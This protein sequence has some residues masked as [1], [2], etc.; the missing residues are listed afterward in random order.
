M[1]S[2]RYIQKVIA[3]KSHLCVGLDPMLEKFPAY[4]LQEAERKYGKT[5]KG[6]GAAI[7][8]FNKLIIDIVAGKMPVVKPQLAYYEKYEQYGIETFWKT[9]DYAQQKGL[10]VLADAK[11]GDIGPTSQA[12][13][14]TFFKGNV[15]AWSSRSAVDAMTVNPYL[16]SNGLDPFVKLGEAE[17]KGT[18]I[19]VKTSNPSSGELQDKIVS[20]EEK[21]IS[22]LVCDYINENAGKI[23]DYGFS[24]IGAVIGATYP[25]ELAKFRKLL[26]HS[27]FL[28]PGIGYQGGDINLLAAA[29]DDNGLGAIISSSRAI[30]YAYED[31]NLPEEEVKRLISQAV[32]SFNGLINGTLAKANKICWEG[33][34]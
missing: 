9:V 22:E 12:Y 21:S 24:D 6:A 25:E 18:I 3:T 15:D 14:E 13:A 33:R 17:G 34:L 5:P 8:E 32:D 28:I 1:F 29:F 10:L 30:D 4:I 7:F 20:P 31:T 27:L 26:P 16:G 2:D 19:L 23:G 11:R